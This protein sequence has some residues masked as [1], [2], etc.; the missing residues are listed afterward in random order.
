MLTASNALAATS[1]NPAAV[2]LA[3]DLSLAGHVAQRARKHIQRER[4]RSQ[5]IEKSAKKILRAENLTPYRRAIIGDLCR[6]AFLTRHRHGQEISAY[7][8]PRLRALWQEAG[9]TEALIDEVREGM[10]AEVERKLAVHELDVK[11]VQKRAADAAKD[12]WEV[13]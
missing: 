4:S 5:A 10:L 3:D 8:L 2:L 1:S 13:I 9:L 12:V 7:V 11:S 6:E